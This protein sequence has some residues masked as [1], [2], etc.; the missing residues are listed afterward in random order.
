M[1]FT[2]NSVVS[3]LPK[4]Q[5]KIKSNSLK[6]KNMENRDPKEKA[7]LDNHANQLNPNSDAYKAGMDNHANQLNPNNDAFD[8][9][10]DDP[11][12]ID[13]NED[14]DDGYISDFD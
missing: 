2:C 7:D 11:G 14:Y 10:D 5:L 6:Q 3:I 8:D 13:Y 12:E 1:P 4:G 9:S